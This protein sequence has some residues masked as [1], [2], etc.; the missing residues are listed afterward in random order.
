MLLHVVVDSKDD[1]AR[2]VAEQKKPAVEDASAAAGKQLYL[3]LSCVNCHAIRGTSSQGAFGPDLTHLMSRRTL[4]SGV[5][6][7]T[8]ENLRAWVND[9]QKIKPG[10]LMP[11]MQLTQEQLNSVV[12]YLSTLK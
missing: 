7:N 1:F 12:G 11:A 9:P 10:S 4:G 8:P 6:D 2:W 5:V 3:S